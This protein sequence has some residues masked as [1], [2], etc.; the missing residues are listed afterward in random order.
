MR[1]KIE[2][3][4]AQFFIK[5]VKIL[6]FVV[7]KNIFIF[8]SWVLYKILGAR[9]RLAT[10]NLKFAY[11]KLSDDDIDDIIKE[12]Y[13]S[14]AITLYETILACVDEAEL[15]YFIEN[16]HEALMRV[17]ELSQNGQRAILFTTAHFGNWEILAHYFA[18]NGFPL[19]VISRESDNALIEQNIVT[20]AR[21][22][23]GNE[24]AYKDHAMSQMVKFLKSGRNVGILIDQKAGDSNSLVTKFFG[25][26]CK[27]AKTIAQLKLKFDPV[28]IPIFSLRLPNGR[29]EIIVKEFDVFPTGDKE[30]DI[31]NITQGLNDVFEEVVRMAPE[32]WFWMHNRWKIN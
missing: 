2:Y 30:Q 31:F 14:L 21:K 15:D 6:P 20:P 19:L 8:F 32:Q 9:R 4:L 1:E 25:R 13:K 16:G 23:F 29:Y 17:N 5:M 28:I 11:P 18:A 24:L 7:A 26:K 3:Y 27:T 12:N 22:K 10:L